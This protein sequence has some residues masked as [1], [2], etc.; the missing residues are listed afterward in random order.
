MFNQNC[1]DMKINYFMAALSHLREKG[2]AENSVRTVL[3]TVILMFPV[4]LHALG[5]YYSYDPN[6][7]YLEKDGIGYKVQVDRNN[8]TAEAEIYGF[9]TSQPITYEE[10]NTD[11]T[12]WIESFHLEYGDLDGYDEYDINQEV[13]ELL[14]DLWEIP[15]T[16]I[17]EN[18][19]YECAD[20]N[21]VKITGTVKSIGRRAFWKSSIRTLQIEYSSENRDI[22]IGEQCFRECR[23]L[24]TLQ[25]GRRMEEIP[26]GMCLCCPALDFVTISPAPNN[27]LK[28]I[29]ALAF[30]NCT[31]LPYFDA[32]NAVEVIGKGAFVNCYALKNI[33]MPRAQNT[34]KSIGDYAFGNC[35]SLVYFD[36]NN[37]LQSIGNGAFFNCDGLTNLTIP[38]S[39]TAIGDYA[40]TGCDN[41]TDLKL[42]DALTTIGQRAFSACYQLKGVEIPNSVTSIGDAAFCGAQASYALW[43]ENALKDTTFL[44][45]ASSFESYGVE[46]GGMKKIVIGNSLDTIA[47]YTFG[48]QVPDTIVCMAPVPP[49]WMNNYVFTRGVYS[50]SVLCV[51]RVLVASYA[52]APG[53]ANFL[54]VEGIEVFG[55]GDLSGNGT[56]DVTDVTLLISM[57]LNNEDV[58]AK[59][60]LNGDGQITV[61]DI[62]ILINMLLNAAN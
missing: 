23:R 36:F 11:S 12:L 28:K 51:P 44:E 7:V 6:V 55:D 24:E 19:F 59:A 39:V 8:Q 26:A 15:V 46:Q 16:S 27:T 60:D 53:W 38:S 37:V 57:A 31:S 61:S 33:W 42:H 21:N 58:S 56:L 22:E 50:G 62:T 35:Y 4:C 20:L 48:G 2:F 17:G 43:N 3:F 45:I 10:W 34:A 30:A 29:G 49:V 18:A 13:K 32:N 40:F 25:I 54:H 47:N 1:D 14:Y 52:A 5:G 9:S 41:L